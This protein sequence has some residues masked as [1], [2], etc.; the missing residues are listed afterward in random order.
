MGLQKGKFNHLLEVARALFFSSEEVVLTATC[1][2]NRLPTYVLNGISLIK[3]IL[4]LFPSSPLML[5]LPSH[6]FGYIAFVHS[7]NPYRG[8]LDP[9]AI[10]CVCIGYPSNKK[11]LSVIT[12]PVAGGSCLEVE[13]VIKLLPFPTHNVQVQEVTPKELITEK[14]H[15]EEGEEDL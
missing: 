12:F 8:K 1:L 4:F 15:N 9:R 14:I 2:I 7:Y 10:K 13:F 6:V 11:G 5:S 3:H